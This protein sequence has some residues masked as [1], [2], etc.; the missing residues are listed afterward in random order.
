MD[1]TGANCTRRA[2]SATAP[3]PDLIVAYVAPQSDLE[4]RLA[5][6]SSDVLGIEGIGVHDNFFEL[7]GDSLQATSF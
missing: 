2:R 3:R 1:D 4:K 6:A 7:G 5:A